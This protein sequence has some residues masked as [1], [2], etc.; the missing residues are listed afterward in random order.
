MKSSLSTKILAICLLTVLIF[1]VL[2]IQ[3]AK[4]I[5]A[6]LLTVREVF[7]KVYDA[8]NARLMTTAGLTAQPVKYTETEILNN[9]YDI[10]NNLLRT[11]GGGGG[12]GPS[13]FNDITS[14]ANTTA[15]MTVG[16]GGSIVPSGSGIVEATIAQEAAAALQGCSLGQYAHNWDNQAWKMTCAQVQFNQLGGAATDAQIP[17][18]NTLGTG[19]TVAKCV[20]TNASTGLLESAAEACGTGSGTAA[21]GSYYWYLKRTD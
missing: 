13:A 6:Q 20:Q 9:V 8:A 21:W 4:Q 3:Y 7:N 11:S 19:L 2:H 16:T 5:E 12:G 15:T 14:G 18:L 1:F 10:D 17:N